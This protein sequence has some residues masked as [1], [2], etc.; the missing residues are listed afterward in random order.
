[1]SVLRTRAM[2]KNDVGAFFAA[3]RLILDGAFVEAQRYL[4]H[5]GW[6]PSDER[7]P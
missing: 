3:L 7:K 1:M 2:I 6:T 4:F 5:A